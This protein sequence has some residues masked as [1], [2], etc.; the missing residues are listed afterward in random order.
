MTVPSP[1]A[2]LTGCILEFQLTQPAFSFL[3]LH[4]PRTFEDTSVTASNNIS[5]LWRYIPELDFSISLN[6]PVLRC[7]QE[8]QIQ[9]WVFPRPWPVTAMGKEAPV[10]F[11]GGHSHL[12]ATDQTLPK[13]Q[14]NQYDGKRSVVEVTTQPCV[15]ATSLKLL[16]PATNETSLHTFNYFSSPNHFITGFLPKT[17]SERFLNKYTNA[18]VLALWMHLMHHVWAAFLRHQNVRLPVCLS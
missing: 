2:P 11:N 6:F 4:H 13:Q 15:I 16:K 1:L 18:Q 5:W 12:T 10:C 3:H 14:N 8:L 7:N 17:S 9:R